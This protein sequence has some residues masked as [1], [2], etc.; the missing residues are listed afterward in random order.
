[1]SAELEP[2]PWC[3][4]GDT[5]I[6]ENGRMWTGMRSSEP[7]SV[8]VRHWCAKVE[9]QPSRMIERVG[10]DRAGAIEAWN[11]RAATTEQHLRQAL[12][13][14]ANGSHW[15]REGAASFLWDTVS[16]E[17]QN[18][19]YR[20]NDTDDAEGVE[21]GRI[22][23]MALRGEDIDWQDDEPMPVEGEP[24]YVA[25]WPRAHP[26]EIPADMVMVPIGEEIPPTEHALPPGY[27][28][29]YDAAKPFCAVVEHSSGRIP[30]ER[31][32]AA[33]W[34]DLAKAMQQCNGP[35]EKK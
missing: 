34:H 6:V 5:Q 12:R 9:G 8:S 19:H 13:F 1:M 2:C 7:T 32:S 15:E 35:A 31:L 22:A 11:R 18:W 20:E 23:K 3:A 17:P 14:Y 10:R 25:A 24:E 30:T 33:N 4:A 29:L 27:S 26:A 21:D 28:E 16:G